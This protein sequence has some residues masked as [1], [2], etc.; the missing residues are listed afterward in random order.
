MLRTMALHSHLGIATHFRKSDAVETIRPDPPVNAV[1]VLLI[2]WT[3][4][5]TTLSSFQ[6]IH[7]EAMFGILRQ[8]KTIG[9]PVG[10]P[11]RQCVR[12]PRRI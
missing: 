4:G 6:P 12:Q 2:P 5:L 7:S 11:I 8:S 3:G 10:E 1:A 9:S